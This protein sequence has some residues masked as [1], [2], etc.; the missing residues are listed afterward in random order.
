[1]REDFLY[2]EP[3]L[4]LIRG[5][6]ALQVLGGQPLNSDVALVHSAE[7]SRI[8]RL[9]AIDA[10]K[11]FG[12]CRLPCVLFLFGEDQGSDELLKFVV[13][14]RASNVIGQSTRGARVVG[15]NGGGQEFE[16][17]LALDAIPKSGEPGSIRQTGRGPLYILAE[18]SMGKS[19]VGVLFKLSTW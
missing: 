3:V 6:K 4:T 1:M 15:G 17:V 9:C 13:G 12:L 10:L 2:M 18:R 11:Q 14:E 19:S 8:L 7:V 16:Q 5:T